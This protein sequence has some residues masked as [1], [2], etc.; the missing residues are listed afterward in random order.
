[1]SDA[2]PSLADGGGEG[3]RLLVAAARRRAAAM[4]QLG[5]P[6]VHRLS[7]WQLSTVRRLL[8]GLIGAVED[9]LRAGLVVRF[10][11][12]QA[13]SASL[14]ARELGIAG[15]AVERGALLAEGELLPHLLRRV[16][17]HRLQ[18]AASERGTLG[19]LP[20]LIGDADEEV[21]ADAMAVMI[22][23]SRRLDRFQEPLMARTE[24]SADL[25][26]KLVWAV[27]AALR[28]YMVRHHEVSPVEADEAIAAEAA[29]MLAA[30]DEGDTLEA[31]ASR[32]TRRLSQLDRLDD[33]LLEAAVTGG[34]L[35]LFIAGAAIRS[36]LAFAPVWDVLADPEARGPPLLLRAAGIGRPAAAAILL[37]LAAGGE[38]MLAAQLDL[39]EATKPAEAREALLLWRIDPAYRAALATLLAPE[40]P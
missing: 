24:L 39:Y 22:A 7:E 18:R 20:L 26:H 23:H 21:A 1:M 3:A 13:L 5:T 8:A 27:A 36:G 25:Q 40:A 6:D 34:S 14:G 28:L 2:R 33:A 4:R 11:G 30:Y 10:A 19:P 16:E 17:E 31:R 32:L 37:A 15:P 12:Q 9:E 38:A 29:A 35:A